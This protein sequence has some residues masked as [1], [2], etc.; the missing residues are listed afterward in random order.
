MRRTLLL[1]SVNLV[2]ILA[3]APAATNE[4]PRRGP[5]DR[6][7]VL[8]GGSASLDYY[9]GDYYAPLGGFL[10]LQFATRV[11][12]LVI[13]GLAVGAELEWDYQ[14]RGDSYPTRSEFRPRLEVAWYWLPALHPRGFAPYL[15]LGAG[16]AAY[17]DGTVGTSGIDVRG[18]LGLLLF[19]SPR[20]ALD[21]ALRYSVGGLAEDG[22]P[23]ASTTQFR[24]A[25]GLAVF[26][27]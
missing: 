19:L 5:L 9:G 18:S 11:S 20:V 1:L 17:S 7:A 26:F 25:C 14:E 15:G 4:A 27:R 22:G 23:T 21:G 10:R 2:A 3:V 16:F 6:H 13:D 12:W 8:V 24:L